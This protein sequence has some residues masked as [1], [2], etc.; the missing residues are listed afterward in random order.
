[1]KI[2]SLAA[3]FLVILIC[4]LT[5]PPVWCHAL[6][7][8]QT[9]AVAPQNPPQGGAA[10]V[11]LPASGSVETLRLLAGKSVVVN[12]PEVLKRV[13]VT[14]EKIAYAVIVSP[15]QVLIHAL[16]PGSV[17]LILWNEREEMRPFELQVQADLRNIR[18]TIQ[19]TFPGESFQI[20]QSGDGVILTGTASSQEVVDRAAAV[21]KTEFP[22]VVNLLAVPVEPTKVVLLQVRFAEVDRSALLQFGINILSTGALNTPGMISTRQFAA[23]GATTLRGVIGAPTPGTASEFQLSDLLNIFVFRPDL[24]LGL[25]IKALQQ[26]NVLQ[27]LAEPNLL[28]V[29]GKE[30]SFLAGGEFPVPIVQGGTGIQTVTVQ[31]KEFGVRL[32]FVA[33]PA[34]DG[35]IHLKVAPEVSALDYAN[36]V[37]LSGFVIPALSTR[38]AETEVDL[39]DGQSFAIAGLLDKRLSEIASKIPVLGDLPFLGNLF[40]SKEWKANNSELLVMVTPHV[41]RPL[42]P[43]QEPALPAFPKPF[44]EEQKFDDGK[45][46]QTSAKPKSPSK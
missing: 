15:N 18:E 23:P 13:S 6:T 12:S 17:T 29:G 42:E 21:I 34:P 31:Y 7:G 24:N 33:N 45:T 46:G 4:T 25:M 10:E 14:D 11:P 1:M 39:R 19:R 32:K 27:I 2:A 30:A 22:N 26:N 41:V 5:T 37:T 16:K 43:G 8:P 35:T 44:L 36:S 3:L 38:K 20:S 9:Q 28:A 40:K